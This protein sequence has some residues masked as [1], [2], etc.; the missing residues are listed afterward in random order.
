MKMNISFTEKQQKCIPEQIKS[1]D[2]R[3][4]SELVREALRIHEFCRHKIIEDLRAEIEKGWDAPVSSKSVKD[5]T[6]EKQTA[7]YTAK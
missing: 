2:Y 1:G 5:I 6:R 4:T 3:N 7:R